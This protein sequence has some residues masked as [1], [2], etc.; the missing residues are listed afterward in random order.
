[1]QGGPMTQS[2]PFENQRWELEDPHIIWLPPEFKEWESRKCVYFTGSRGSGKTTLLK[3]FEWKERLYNKSIKEQIES[4]PFDKK[5][6]GVYLLVTDYLSDRFK[7]WPPK[8]KDMNLLEWKNEKARL[9]SLFLEYHILQLSINAILEL[10]SKGILEFEPSSERSTAIKI[11]QF[12]PEISKFVGNQKNRFGLM[13]LE[14]AFRE[15]HGLIARYAVYKKDIDMELGLPTLQMGKM[16]EYVSGLLADLCM[17]NNTDK[18]RWFF[19]ICIDQAESLKNYQQKAINTM[20]GALKTGDISFA[21]AF[22]SGNNEIS[23]NYLINHTLTEA[24]RILVSLEDIYKSKTNFLNFVTRVSEMRIKKLIKYGD[25]PFNLKNILGDYDL[26]YLLY[27]L[28][29]KRSEKESVRAFIK[30]ASEHKYVEL[31]IGKTKSDSDSSSD[32]ADG[33]M[34][35]EDEI[36]EYIP[37]EDEKFEVPPFY[38]IY[39]LKKL[40]IDISGIGKNSQKIRTLKSKEFRKKMVSAMLCLCKEYRVPIPFAGYSMVLSLSDH[41]IR[42]YF[43][44]MNEFF[45]AEGLPIEEFIKV[46]ISATK[47]DVAIRKV[48]EDRYKSIDSEVPYRTSEIRNM[49]DALGKITSEL[50]SRYDDPSS[51]RSTERGRFEINTAHLKPYTKRDLEEI[52]QLAIEC[53]FIKLLHENVEDNKLIFRLHRIFAPK[54]NFSY[55]GAFYNVPLDADIFLELCRTKDNSNIIKNIPNSLIKP[56]DQMLLD[57]FEVKK[58]D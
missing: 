29:L 11:L 17:E 56:N 52:I 35:N 47:Q 8:R 10:R 12:C 26:N 22:L 39:L 33:K 5:Y 36:D 1:M 50:Q 19:K 20:V 27:N 55:R 54:Y 3:A 57:A 32:I 23:K 13:E 2:S 58:L 7:N 42:D 21:V 6:I 31:F 14:C 51:L 37:K 38:Q 49:V 48:S 41:C 46:T 25:I 30:E 34:Q 28:S 43:R 15:M 18:S 53:H 24:D 44:L 40:N 9:Y 45:L 16:L 4:E